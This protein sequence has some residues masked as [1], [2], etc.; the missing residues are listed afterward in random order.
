MNILV[1]GATGRVGKNLVKNLKDRGE[2][3][4]ALVLPGDSGKDSLINSGIDC[5][6]G[7]LSNKKVISAAV[8]GI[9]T[10]VH[11]AA[12]MLWDPDTEPEVFQQNIEGTFNLLQASA[13]SRTHMKRIFLASSDE[14]YPS[15]MARYRPIDEQHPK[16]PYSFYGLSK[17]I[18]ERMALYYHR[19]CGLPITIARFALI[20]EAK[21]LL[22]PDGWSG[23]FVFVEPM[24]KLFAALGRNDAVEVLNSAQPGSEDT[25]LIALDEQG[26]PYL[27]HFC[28]VRDLVEGIL[29][30][31]DKPEAIGQVFNLSGPAP[32]SYR[33][34]VEEL[35][36]RTGIP[37]VELKIPGTPIRIQH[38]ISKAKSVL[39]Y[40]PKFDILKVIDS[41]MND[42]KLV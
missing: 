30:Q 6:S 17:E 2:N 22:S 21:E 7:T 3:V 9:E 16:E 40:Q 39:G 19:S 24:R 20:A 28:D 27:F 18:N 41:A 4:R 38:D 35:H 5:I 14:V 34:A 25:L 42:E 33:V 26:N 23:R 29:L 8:E 12:V 37:Y 13:R 1:T 11:L 32:F 31:L 36:K 10:I 15:L